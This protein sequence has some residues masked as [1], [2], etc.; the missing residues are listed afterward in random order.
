ME[1]F[2]ENIVSVA[3]LLFKV[4]AILLAID[5][6]AILFGFEYRVPYIMNITNFIFA[7]VAAL[8]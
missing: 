7:K 1:A 3:L 5:L 2:W 4:L 8:T 6:A